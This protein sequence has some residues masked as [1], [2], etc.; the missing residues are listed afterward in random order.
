LS[1]TDEP[2]D[3]VVARF[4]GKGTGRR[5]VGNPHGIEK[6]EGSLVYRRSYFFGSVAGHHQ[7]DLQGWPPW[8]STREWAPV[9]GTCR[10]IH[11]CYCSS[12]THGWGLPVVTTTAKHI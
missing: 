6:L 5:Q 10:Q 4:E 3:N 11:C 8:C 1:A 9:H 12:Y 2:D 7:Y